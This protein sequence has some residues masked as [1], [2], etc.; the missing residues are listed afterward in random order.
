MQQT[1]SSK[2]TFDS[3]VPESSNTLKFKPSEVVEWDI[4]LEEAA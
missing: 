4:Y 1:L 3:L 2:A